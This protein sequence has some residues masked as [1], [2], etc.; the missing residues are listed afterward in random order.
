MT[1]TKTQAIPKGF[2]SITPHMIVKGAAA[3]IDFLK[4]AFGA[5]EDGRMPGPGGRIM[6]AQV[7]IGDSKLMF[8]D[9]FPEFGGPAYAEGRFPV[10]LHL[11]VPDADKT[12]AQ[13][14]AAGCTATMPLADQFWGD[15]Y[16]HVVDPFGFTWAIATHKEDLTPEEMQKRQA[17]AFAKPC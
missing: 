8:G 15:R 11:Y 16:G 3:Y 10:V 6:H 13:A 17:A 2:H 5:V 4:R 7:Q 1:A 12:F 9:H 14:L